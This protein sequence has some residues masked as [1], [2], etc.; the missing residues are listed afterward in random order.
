MLFQ[1]GAEDHEH[2]DGGKKG[3]TRKQTAWELALKKIM[4]KKKR[5]EERDRKEPPVDLQERA[6]K[7]KIRE[8][9]EKAEENWKV[10]NHQI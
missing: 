1:D 8:A 7:E 4:Q 9:E 3:A 5:Q 10:L 6:R 2:C